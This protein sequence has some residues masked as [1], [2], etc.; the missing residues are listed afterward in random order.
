M[1][2]RMFSDAMSELDNKYIDEAVN[3][4]RKAGR[5]V[6]VKWGAAAACLC[7]AAAAAIFGLKQ[8]VDD[9]G[10]FKAHIFSSYEEFAGVVP[11]I[12][13]V[14]NLSKL[15][16]VDVSIYGTFNDVSIEDHT[17]MENYRWFDIKAKQGEK[18]VAFVHLILNDENSADAYI[19][20]NALVNEMEINGEHIFYAYNAGAEYW[21]AVVE[22]DGNYCNILYYAA[23][24]RDFIDVISVLLKD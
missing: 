15:D 19:K 8:R 1:N 20:N 12:K 11:D 6:W 18:Y 17:R 22:M 5:S 16:G 21:D 2:G 24:E 23:S 9:P 4:K 3:Y 10:E 7:L 14:E 13:I